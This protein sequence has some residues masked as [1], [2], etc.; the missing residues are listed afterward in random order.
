MPTGRSV[1]ITLGNPSICPRDVK[2]A[3]RVTG[4]FTI[5]LAYSLQSVMS[6]E[7]F[8]HNGTGSVLTRIFAR[9][10]QLERWRKGVDLLRSAA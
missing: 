8:V 2:G 1:A 3:F 7:P 10:N 9:W 6:T 5:K 4:G